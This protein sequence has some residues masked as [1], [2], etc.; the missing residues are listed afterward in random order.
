MDKLK[1]LREVVTVQ[2][3]NKKTAGQSGGGG[4]A[5]SVVERSDVTI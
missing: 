2:L 4:F 1:R 3:S 5:T